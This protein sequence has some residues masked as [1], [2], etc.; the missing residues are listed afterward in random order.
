MKRKNQTKMTTR[1]MSK[2]SLV[3]GN[4]TLATFSERVQ[5]RFV[6][7][8]VPSIEQ[9]IP[10][11]RVGTTKVAILLNTID[12]YELTVRCIGGALQRAGYPYEL[13]CCDNGSSDHRVIDY[14][15]T[16]SPVYFRQ[17]KAND[18]CAQMHNQMLLRTDAELFCLLDNDIE[19]KR[20]YWLKD[21]VETYLAVDNSGVAGIH[22]TNL[23]PEHHAV[24]I[25]HGVRIHP[26]IPPKEDAIFGTRLFGRKVLAKVGFFCEDYGPYGL[27]DNEFNT[28]VF[29]SGFTNYYIPGES[30]EHL[31]SD[32]GENSDYRR[33]KDESMR[34]AQP[35]MVANMKRYFDSG[36]FYVPPPALC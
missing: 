31:G 14:I 1:K 22:S 19:I 35:K 23:C 5:S 16:L 4:S 32:V 17:N 15:E 10:L 8:E 34:V 3:M 30:G 12:R 33:M 28:R 29:H 7:E 24:A 20:D 11:L 2:N 26:A 9:A 6:E 21:L 36:N 25:I 13:L 27:V 18:G